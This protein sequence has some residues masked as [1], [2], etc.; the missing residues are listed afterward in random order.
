MITILTFI[1]II[2]SILLI[3]FV[4]LHF[5]KGAESGLVLD[6]SSSSILPQKGNIMNKIT[7]TLATLFLVISLSLAVLRSHKSGSS[8]LDSI[9][10]SKE[11]SQSKVS[12]KK[13]KKADLSDTDSLETKSEQK[14]VNEK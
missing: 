14:K 1:H 10:E 7:G 4:I 2:V 11:Q 8:L 9:P 3:L 12:D 6:T 13:T 5:G